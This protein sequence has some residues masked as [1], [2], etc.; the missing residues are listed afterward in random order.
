MT[1]NGRNAGKPTALAMV[2]CDTVLRDESTKKMALVGLFDMIST[3]QVPVRHDRMHIF[4]SVTDGHGRMPFLVQCRAPDERIIFEAGGEV[5]F[6]D[7]L[8]VTDLNIE[9]RGL[10]FHVQGTYI[11]EFYCGGEL[12][13][14]RRFTVVCPPADTSESNS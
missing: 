1:E 13:A 9:A 7:P 8:A 2:V 3:P 5:E 4:I 12:L 10:I 14:M 11:F 6:M